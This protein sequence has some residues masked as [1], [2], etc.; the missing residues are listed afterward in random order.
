[1][2]HIHTH[3]S[4]SDLA[5]LYNQRKRC[6][7]IETS[8]MVNL[9]SSLTTCFASVRKHH[10]ES[11]GGTHCRWLQASRISPCL[12]HPL[13]KRL[14]QRINYQIGRRIFS[15]RLIVESTGGG[16]SALQSRWETV[17][18]RLKNKKKRKNE[19][20]NEAN[21]ENAGRSLR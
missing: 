7:K 5:C 3:P 10:G 17:G 16:S 12:M 11:S 20:A 9:H 19:D 2:I 8:S 6:R 13:A 14:K 21:E 4:R 1:M 18:G 15:L